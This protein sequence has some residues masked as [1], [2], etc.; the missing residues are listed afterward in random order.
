MT[1]LAVDGGFVLVMVV[2]FLYQFH[3]VDPALPTVQLLPPDQFKILIEQH[4]ML[5]EEARAS[6]IAVFNLIVLQLLLPV[7]NL[8]LGY[9]FGK[10]R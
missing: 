9:L 6:V 2:W 5:A 3:R 8:M 10:Q 1:I 4:K 7:F